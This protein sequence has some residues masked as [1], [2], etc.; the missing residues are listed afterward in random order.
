M[1]LDPYA[2]VIAAE[3]YFEALGL[4]T[5]AAIDPAETR[6][7]FVLPAAEHHIGDAR[8]RTV[9]GGVVAA[10]L[11][12]AAVITLRAEGS[13][14]PGTV[15]FTTDFVRGARMLD[16]FA[17]VEVIRRGRRLAHLRVDAWQERP[18]RLVAFGAGSFTLT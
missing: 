4:R 7:W 15:V 2:A 6:P 11:E 13:E 3:P 1:T 9:H 10:F 8:Y 14:S 17:K 18:Q 5:C 16:T 12:C